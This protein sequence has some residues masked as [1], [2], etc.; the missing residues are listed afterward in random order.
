V[1]SL[2]ISTTFLGVSRGFFLLLV[3]IVTDL[4]PV[5]GPKVT[6]VLEPREVEWTSEISNL[7]ADD[8]IHVEY[9]FDFPT[10]RTD[11]LQAKYYNVL[12]NFILSKDISSW[13]GS[14][15]KKSCAQKYYQQVIIDLIIKWRIF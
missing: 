11:P 1:I 13:I 7:R 6:I 3:S 8:T 5:K 9:P 12:K 4:Q 14:Q 2:F 15:W 10:I